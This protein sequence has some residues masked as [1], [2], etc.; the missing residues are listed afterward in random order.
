M[1]HLAM[2]L[3]AVAGLTIGLG[4][5]ASAADMAVKAPIYKAPVVELYNWTGFYVGGNAGYA[6]GNANDAMNLGG[7]WLLPGGDLVDNQ[8]LTPFGNGRL[9][10]NGF[11]G[12]VQAGYNYQAGQWVLGIETD[13]NYLNLKNTF[14]TGQVQSTN[15]PY[16]FQSSFESNWLLTLRP[17][18]GYAV[19]RFLI[20]ATGGLAVANQKVS[21]NI[22]ELD[23]AFIQVGSVSKTTA[24]WTVGVG[25]EYALSNNWSFKTEYLYVDPGKVSASS[26]G[27]CR[28]PNPDIGCLTFATDYTGTHEAHLKANI[29]RV[30]IDYHFGGP[31]VA[32]Y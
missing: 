29:V 15:S 5:T 30:G 12:G 1:K 28:G 26:L 3:F 13:F 10:P 4:Q 7:S 25:A 21:Q 18:I 16:T 22:T 31:V 14:A 19:D 2:A 23:N 24:G 11:I 20:Y 6:W 8:L 9:K 17:R 27:A 32:K